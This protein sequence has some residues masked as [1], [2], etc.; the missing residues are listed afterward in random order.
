MR[1]VVAATTIGVG[2]SGLSHCLP[3]KTTH[4]TRIAAAEQGSGPPAGS[5]PSVADSTLET[6]RSAARGEQ[7]QSVTEL[8]RDREG[9]AVQIPRPVGPALATDHGGTPIPVAGSAPAEPVPRGRGAPREPERPQ[10]AA[11]TAV[12]RELRGRDSIAV[13]IDS[14]PPGAQVILGGRVLGTTPFH[15]ELARQA[16]D[17][18][19][20]IRLAAYAERVVVAP[21]SQA[22]NK[23]VRLVR[24]STVKP[25]K[26]DP[27]RIVNPFD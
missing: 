14:D 4:E 5:A 23:Q 8:V 12:R 25:A 2:I 9:S 26:P 18:T 11:A 3:S 20:V 27:N 17:V 7:G 16:H 22:I 6:D 1:L 10:S 19:F 24:N 13:A 15:G 21:A